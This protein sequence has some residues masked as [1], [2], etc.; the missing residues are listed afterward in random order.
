MI[1]LRGM[2]DETFA[3]FL[4]T[5]PDAA[6]AVTSYQSAN[7][8]DPALQQV[9]YNPVT[10]IVGPVPTSYGTSLGLPVPGANG[11]SDWLRGN[12][13]LLVTAAVALVGIVAI[14]GRK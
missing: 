7:Q 5:H 3:D 10:G 6:A 4:T 9:M 12:T 2:G 14:S 8:G 1:S 11:F 13:T